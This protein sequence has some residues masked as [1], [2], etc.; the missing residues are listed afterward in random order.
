MEL[1]TLKGGKSLELCYIEDYLGGF[2]CYK[3]DSKIFLSSEHSSVICCE[4]TKEELEEY[5]QMKLTEDDICKV[6]KDK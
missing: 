2:V 6:V 5:L 3:K 4:G 1:K